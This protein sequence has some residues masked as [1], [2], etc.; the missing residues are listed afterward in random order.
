MCFFK[1]NVYVEKLWGDSAFRNSTGMSLLP[2]D[3]MSEL[4]HIASVV[5]SKS[6]MREFILLTSFLGHKIALDDIIHS[7][8]RKLWS[9]ICPYT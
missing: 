7:S 3:G 5:G 1:C 2:S 4:Y 8:L 6:M 9:L